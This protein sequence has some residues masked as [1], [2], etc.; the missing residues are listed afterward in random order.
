MW[1][2]ITGG[3]EWHGEF[4]NRKKNG[5][6]YSE[7]ASISPIRDE[8]GRIINFVAVKEDITER[9]RTA[10]EL[11]EHKENEARSRRELEHEKELNQVKSRFV[12]LVSHEFRSPLCVIGMAASLLA[13][14]LDKM[15]AEQR[16][17]NIRRIQQAVVRMTRMMED[18]LVHEK[19]GLRK[20]E[21][22]PALLDV[23]AFCLGLIAGVSPA[24]DIVDCHV[25]ADAREAFVDERILVHIVGNVLNNAVKY[26]LEG[27][28]VVLEVTRVDADAR[29]PE[30]LVFT[31]RDSGIGIPEK[32]FGNLFETFHRSSNVGNRPGTGMGMAIAKQFVDLLGGEIEVQSQ[33][34]VGTTVR[35]ALP[36]LPAASDATPSQILITP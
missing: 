25:A 1:E 20:V 31:V 35:I 19:L 11:A 17:G 34:G 15:S 8:T 33:E 7:Q 5:D 12:S 22:K 36:I 4:R 13:D 14:Y 16:D 9:K 27:G 21:N 10:A 23:D 3:R 28:R 2:T 26:S 30:A 18:L 32:D 6:V 29:L 24:S